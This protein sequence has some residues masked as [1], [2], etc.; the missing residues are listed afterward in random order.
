VNNNISKKRA[1][2]IHS[3]GVKLRA[4]GPHWN[5]QQDM[6]VE[7]FRY[8]YINKKLGSKKKEL[9]FI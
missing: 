7:I 8:F 9:K 1:V 4:G 2:L 5:T 3:K 6:T